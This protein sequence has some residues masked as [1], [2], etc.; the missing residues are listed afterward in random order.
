MQIYKEIIKGEIK[1]PKDCPLI[2]KE[3]IEGLLK[4]NAGERINNF[5]KIKECQIFKD[6]DWDNLLRKKIKPFFLPLG[7]ELGG[8]AN[9]NN[10]ASPFEKFIQN[11]WV[12]TSEMHLLRIKNKNKNIN[13]IQE[14]Y[15]SEFINNQEDQKYYDEENNVE[16]SNHWFDY[17]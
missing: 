6:F 13:Y 2:V 9:L 11:E 5:D 4:R 15:E 17:F 7:D 8:K 12:E 10:L 3:L 16:F 14:Q 1:I